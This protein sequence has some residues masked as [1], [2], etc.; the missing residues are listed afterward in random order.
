MTHYRIRKNGDHWIV[1]R[2]MGTFGWLPI[3]GTITWSAA[4]AAVNRRLR[5]AR[6]TQTDYALA[7]PGK[8]R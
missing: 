7:A 6:G 8:A 4:L 3:V 2:S 1:Y 5:R